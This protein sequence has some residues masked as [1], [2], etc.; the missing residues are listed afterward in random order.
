MSTRLQR[1]SEPPWL[2]RR[3]DLPI[4][5]SYRSPASTSFRSLHWYRD[6]ASQSSDVVIRRDAVGQL[7]RLNTNDCIIGFTASRQVHAAAARLVAAMNANQA[8][9]EERG[10]RR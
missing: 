8:F 1:A 3:I 6:D 7:A 5:F 2:Q 4:V 10:L 9:H